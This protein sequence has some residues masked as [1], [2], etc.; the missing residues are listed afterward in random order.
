MGVSEGEPRAQSPPP[1]HDDA[2]IKADTFISVIV[3][4]LRG[5]SRRAVKIDG[6]DASQLTA[7]RIDSIIFS[8]E[9]V[10]TSGFDGGLRST[11]EAPMVLAYRG[12][13][14]VAAC[15]SPSAGRGFEF[16]EDESRRSSDR[17]FTSSE[18]S[19]VMDLTSEA[20]LRLDDT[21]IGG[22]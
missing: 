4:G 20:R 13:R 22:D 1:H 18:K 21:I 15:N 17:G 11:G 3:R 6:P 19:L 12:R 8:D 5:A 9:R 2:L 7:S 10:D 14:P 16:A